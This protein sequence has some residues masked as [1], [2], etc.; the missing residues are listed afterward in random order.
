MFYQMFFSNPTYLFAKENFSILSIEV[1]RNLFWFSDF[2]RSKGCKVRENTEAECRG[3]FCR[4][5]DDVLRPERRSESTIFDWNIW[6]SLNTDCR[7]LKD[8]KVAVWGQILFCFET[9]K[10]IKLFFNRDKINFAKQKRTVF[11]FVLSELI[12]KYFLSFDSKFTKYDL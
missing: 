3:C 4:M 7:S 5:K 2:S 1:D 11:Q 10:T 12:L 9:T 8:K 6:I